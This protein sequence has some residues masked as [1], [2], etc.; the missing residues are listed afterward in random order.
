MGEGGGGERPS[1]HAPSLSE[2][3]AL[4]GRL[5]GAVGQ[6]ELLALLCSGTDCGNGVPPIPPDAHR[7]ER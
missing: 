3:A 1:A 2:A 4:L 7:Q 6:R 5:S